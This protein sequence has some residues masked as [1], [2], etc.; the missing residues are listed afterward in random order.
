MKVFNTLPEGGRPERRRVADELLRAPRPHP[1]LLERSP[2][3]TTPSR[4]WARPERPSA[5]PIAR[6]SPEFFC[7][8]RR[9]PVVGRS[10]TE[11]ETTYQTDGVAIVTDGVLA[12]CAWR[13]PGRH[14]PPHPRGRR[15]EDH[16]RSPA[17][18]TS[19]S[20][21]RRRGSISRWRRI[22][23][24]AVPIGATGAARRRW[25]RGSLRARRS[26]RAG[27]DRRAQR[28][29]EKDGR[30]AKDDG[31]GRVPLARRA[32]PRR[33]CRGGAADAAARA[34]GRAAAPL[35]SVR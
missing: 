9:Q 27:G 6:V 25:S 8:A 5:K 19:A 33:S 24:S 1:R 13:R 2:S 28:R 20:C 18:R 12:A 23:S 17:A 30:D 4:S 29:V 3:T 32:A 21:R 14:R 15:R 35:R 16:R 34:G 7:D 22:P 11:A 10:F 26:R 31:S